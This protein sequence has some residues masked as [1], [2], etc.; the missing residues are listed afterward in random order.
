MAVG[1]TREMV[2]APAAACCL[3]MSGSCCAPLARPVCSIQLLTQLRPTSHIS[4]HRG[5]A[6]ETR[7]TCECVQAQLWQWRPLR[8]CRQGLCWRSRA[9]LTSRRRSTEKTRTSTSAAALMQL[10]TLRLQVDL[11]HQHPHPAFCTLYQC[12]A[13]KGS[14]QR[15]LLHLQLSMG[16]SARLP[17]QK[18]E[19]RVKR[20]KRRVMQ[21][22]AATQTEH[23][24]GAEA[25]LLCCMYLMTC[26][27]YCHFASIMSCSSQSSFCCQL[28]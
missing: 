27:H 22:D 11:W 1:T 14:L 16:L 15:L 17:D 20:K 7:T 18:P 13:D 9:S 21:T 28:Q 8:R 24:Q 2:L 23:V 10:Q 6:R 4:I 12:N 5:E 26:S 19:K 25:S 3:S